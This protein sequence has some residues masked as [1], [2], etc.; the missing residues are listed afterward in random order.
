MHSSPRKGFKHSPYLTQ[1]KVDTA[2]STILKSFKITKDI[3]EDVLTCIKEIHNAKNEYQEHATSEI[4][5]QI[6]KLQKRIEQA[7][8]DKCD[9]LVDE[10]FWQKNNK[11][12]HAEKQNY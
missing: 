2:I 5:T 1:D 7:Y 12:W 4:M 11:K 10:E 3:I 6:S 8:Q 9:G